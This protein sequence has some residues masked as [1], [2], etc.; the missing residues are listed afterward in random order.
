MS[1]LP[2][3]FQKIKINDN[4][5]G[6]RVQYLVSIND[7]TSYWVQ[8]SICERDELV[9]LRDELNNLL[10]ECT[11]SEILKINEEKASI[12]DKFHLNEKLCLTCKFKMQACIECVFTLQSP[13]ERLLFLSMK[14][15][16]IYFKTQYGIN[17][18]GQ[19]VATFDRSFDDP[20]YNFKGVLTVVD[21]YIESHGKKLCVYTDGHTY[22]ER[23][24]DQAIHDRTIDRKLQELN[25]KVLRYTGK[26]V[27][28]SIDKVIK[29]IN[30][31]L[32]I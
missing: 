5:K 26:E 17:W 7:K 6:E 21:F 2:I 23:T 25:F 12:I 4:F 16:N 13:I 11:T 1:K 3:K 30:Q 32:T 31:W 27:N 8:T 19:H 22:H 29:E 10:S 28:E 9:K 18:K 20:N 14:E 15:N 24:E